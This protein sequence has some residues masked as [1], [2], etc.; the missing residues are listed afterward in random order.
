MTQY[1]SPKPHDGAFSITQNVYR[2]GRGR[3][4]FRRLKI[5]SI[6]VSEENASPPLLRELSSREL[7]RHSLGV[8]V[9]PLAQPRCRGPPLVFLNGGP[10][11]SDRSLSYWRCVKRQEWGNIVCRPPVA[12]GWGRDLCAAFVDRGKR[13]SHTGSTTS[14]R[15]LNRHHLCRRRRSRRLNALRLHRRQQ[16]Q[17]LPMA[18]QP[19]F[20][21]RR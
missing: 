2:P 8:R 15:W 9:P 19:S 16:D 21:H 18:A 4:A 12:S 14:H 1:G 6:H 7:R 5:E 13:F 3:A 11:L 10:W 20:F 17:V